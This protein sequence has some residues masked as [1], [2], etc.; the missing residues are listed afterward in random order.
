MCFTAEKLREFQAGERGNWLRPLRRNGEKEWKDLPLGVQQI[1]GGVK[2]EGDLP[3]GSETKS[4]EKKEKN[5]RSVC[6]SI[7]QEAITG[8]REKQGTTPVVMRLGKHGIDY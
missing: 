6:F 8:P 4:G 7:Q 3:R 1:R 2:S 5:G